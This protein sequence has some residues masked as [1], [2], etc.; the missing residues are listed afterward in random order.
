MTELA[1]VAS[2][3]LLVVTGG[4][5]SPIWLLIAARRATNDLF[6]K[7]LPSVCAQ[8]GSRTR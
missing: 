7:A 3:E 5:L 1:T 8:N 6:C 4:V 2:A